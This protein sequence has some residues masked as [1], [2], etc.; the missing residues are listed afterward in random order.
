MSGN[1]LPE[2]GLREQLSFQH[3][4]EQARSL[5]SQI[6]H[7]PII[8][9]TI[10]GGLWYGAGVAEEIDDGIRFML[11]VF[12]GVCNIAFSLSLLRVR[13]VLESY[14]EKIEAFNPA[15]FASGKPKK[16]KMPL[17]QN[18]SVVRM[19]SLLMFIAGLC[20]FFVALLKYWP[21]SNDAYFYLF[22]AI[23]AYLILGYLFR[24]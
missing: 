4:F 9:I 5:I 16:P 8:A 17:L 2:P 22:D 10:T 13:D 15:T 14:L 1:I 19:F 23:A 11:M 24:K 12:A 6:N 21:F 18:Y 7:I 20:S 3:N